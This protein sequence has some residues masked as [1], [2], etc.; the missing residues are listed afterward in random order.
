MTTQTVHQIE[1]QF[2]HLSSED[3]KLLL[4]RLAQQRQLEV[5]RHNGSGGQL[6]GPLAAPRE[7]QRKA[8]PVEFNP[9]ASDL[10]SEAW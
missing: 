3:Q 8:G 2:A 4:D 1:E 6:A 5:A 9:A 10:L 7:L